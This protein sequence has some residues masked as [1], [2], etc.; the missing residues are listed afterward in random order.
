MNIQLDHIQ[1]L[2][3]HALLGAQRGDVATIRA[4][5]TLQDRLALD[6]DEE[7][8]I[9][10]TRE[11]IDGRE[12][13][14]WNPTRAIPLKEFQLTDQ[15]V[16]LVTAALETWGSYSANGDRRWLQPLIEMLVAASAR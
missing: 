7:N 1:R 11:Y 2:N 12:R 16:A 14:V 15:D 10:L 13:V 8:S 5:W 3:L 6:P 4:I 9:E